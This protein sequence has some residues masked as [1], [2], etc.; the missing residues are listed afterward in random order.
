MS[1]L[2]EHRSVAQSQ[3]QTVTQ[4][5]RPIPPR[6]L[7]LEQCCFCCCCGPRFT[8]C[9]STV[10]GS[11]SSLSTQ[12]NN[13]PTHSLKRRFSDL[14]QDNTH[15]LSKHTHSAQTAQKIPAEHLIGSVSPKILSPWVETTGHLS[16]YR[17]LQLGIL[18]EKTPAPESLSLLNPSTLPASLPSP[19]S[20]APFLA[21]A[22]AF[23]VSRSSKVSHHTGSRAKRKACQTNRV[24]RR[25]RRQPD[26]H[27]PCHT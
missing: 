24:K 27:N 8:V 1:I 5:G 12:C 2:R 23:S 10:F 7:A 13:G 6:N 17:P 4:N 14:Q 21:L 19:W 16:S 9:A 18:I 20:F 3:T 11:H 22:H 15:T 26:P 25:R